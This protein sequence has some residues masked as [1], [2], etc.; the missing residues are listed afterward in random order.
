MG[1]SPFV[2]KTWWEL[3]Q[4]HPMQGRHFSEKARE[5]MSISA[6]RRIHPSK[7][8]TAEQAARQEACEHGDKYY[9][10][11][12]PCK[13]GHV[14]KR[15]VK[16]T[17]CAK[18]SQDQTNE[19]YKERRQQSPELTMRTSAKKR[20]RELGIEFAVTASDIR[21]VW[22]EDGKCPIL[23]LEL[24]P[25]TGKGPHDQSPSLDRL[26]PKLGYVVGNI[27][28]ISYLANRIK[29]N[30]TDPQIFDNLADWLEGLRPTPIGGTHVCSRPSSGCPCYRMWDTARRNAEKQGLA[31]DLHPTD[32][33]ALWPK[34]GRCPITGALLAQN[35]RKGP[36]AS[37]PSLDRRI[38]EL[39]YV[40]GNVAV[41][42]HL[43]NRMK[44]NVT[45]PN[46]FRRMAQWLRQ[47]EV[48][49]V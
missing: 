1:T 9:F 27:A 36:S 42:S 49:H 30:V 40:K 24:T 34:G 32:V 33:V 3:G 22:P 21:A 19:R 6:Q 31:F 15:F 43:A 46:V 12:R 29:Q 16:T 45:D 11:P 48:L 26:N 23:G 13:R 10:F 38:P 18:C 14:Y 37:S 39:G 2:G 7:L 8:G 20:A 44:N 41:I 35:D 17:S 47:Q 5:K 28:V 4:T 25:N